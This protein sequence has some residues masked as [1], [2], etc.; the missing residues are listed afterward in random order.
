MLIPLLATIA[1]FAGAF[2]TLVGVGGGL[3]IVPA[4]T[5]LLGVPLK[6]AAAASLVGVAATSVVGGARYL[7]IGVADRRLGL[8]LLVATASGAIAG[9]F[10][11]TSLDVRVLSGLFAIVLTFVA[12]QMIRPPRTGTEGDVPPGSMSLVSSFIEP[13]SG[14]EKAYRARRLPAAFGVS[15]IAGSLSGL[16]GI[17]GG[18][19]NVPT[20]TILMGVP[21]RVAVSTS[22]YML[23]AT[24]AASAAIY[25]ARGQ[26][27]PLVAAPVAI[28]ILVGAWAGARLSTRV[29]QGVLRGLFAA[30]AIVL[31][32]QMGARVL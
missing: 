10:F 14:R 20:M 7:E 11:A 13:G 1:V 15:L 8:I 3:I 17:G 5:L 18:V 28:G 26:L 29:S 16:L 32:I 31:A 25:Y 2:G 21:V 24:A 27:D 12:L 22:T 9:G 6:S 30:L 23:G 4:L 19:V